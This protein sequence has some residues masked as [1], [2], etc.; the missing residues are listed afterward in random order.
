MRVAFSGTFH[1]GKT[2]LIRA[3]TEHLSNYESF[4]EPYVL[5]ADEGCDFS[6]SPTVE[7]YAQQMERSLAVIQG[8]PASALIDRCPLD[9]HGFA[10]A[11]GEGDGID[12]DQWEYE[13]RVALAKVDVIVFLPI[14]RP[15]R[16]ELPSTEDA[17]FRQTVDDRLR[18]LV[19]EDSLGLLSDTDVAEVTGS[20][21]E[22]VRMV[23]NLIE[24]SGSAP[25]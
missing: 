14:E 8:S 22:R 6:L 7:E 18:E 21:A 12:L 11:A 3:L 10:Q 15:D 23:I 9:Y 5:L 25:D 17:E 16:I 1:S 13:T 2:T 19:L 20:L 24:R 4:E